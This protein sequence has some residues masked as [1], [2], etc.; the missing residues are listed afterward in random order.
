MVTRPFVIFIYRL[1]V[2]SAFVVFDL[3][4]L[5]NDVRSEKESRKIQFT[6]NVTYLSIEGSCCSVICYK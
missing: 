5:L 1:Q 3:L 2:E 4:V 6:S